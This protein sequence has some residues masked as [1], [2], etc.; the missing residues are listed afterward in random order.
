[1][2]K[3]TK[4][5][6][7]L[8]IVAILFGV[9][10]TGYSIWNKPQRDVK[11]SPVVKISSLDL[12]SGLSKKDS[13]LKS[14]LLNNVVEVS[15]EIS[16]VSLNQQHQQIILLKTNIS[17]GSIN[18]TMEETVDKIKPGDMIVLKG[19]CSGYIGGDVEMELPGD[20]YLTRCYFSN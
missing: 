1:M 13:V 14:A 6:I 3:Q 17:G 4:R 18:C 15:G 19:I 12:Y 16:A 8:I 11:N 2:R 7:L 10:I 9:V 20:V 5:N